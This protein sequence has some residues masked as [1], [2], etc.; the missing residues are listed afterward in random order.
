MLTYPGSEGKEG[1]EE[2]MERGAEEIGL[3]FSTAEI[4]YGILTREWWLLQRP[5]SLRKLGTRLCLPITGTMGEIREQWTRTAIA[6]P[7]T[8]L[9]PGHHSWGKGYSLLGIF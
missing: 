5:W 3:A 8:L 6:G 9:I 4:R 2:S 7:L 1:E